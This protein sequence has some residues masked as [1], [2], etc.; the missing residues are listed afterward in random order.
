MLAVTGD[1]EGGPVMIS[2]MVIAAMV[3]SAAMNG[4]R[5]AFVTCLRE[6]VASAKT[7][8]VAGDAFD[9]YVRSKCAPIE[10]SFTASMVAFD[11]KNK[12]PRKQ[13][14]SDAKLQIDDY[15]AGAVDRYKAATGAQ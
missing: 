9:A 6:A 14:A 2:A 3:Q 1:S 7:D 11:L 8:K 5:Q 15:V 12:V 4:Q 13:A 10:Q